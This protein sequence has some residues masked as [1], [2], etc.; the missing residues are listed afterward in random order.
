MRLRHFATKI[1]TR[2]LFISSP[3]SFIY[4][5]W[6]CRVL[7]L[8]FLQKQW[9]KVL[10]NPLGKACAEVFCSPATYEKKLWGR[11]FV[12]ELCEILQSSF[13]MESLPTSVLELSRI[14]YKVIRN[15]FIRNQVLPDTSLKLT[16]HGVSISGRIR[17]IFYS[18][19][20]FLRNYLSLSPR[21]S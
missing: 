15:S 21:L 6:P 13:S 11:C 20:L 10:A 14:P 4:L 2:K 5:L 18:K 8:D 1:W 7:V 19:L 17:L 16:M 9:K 3:R 12:T